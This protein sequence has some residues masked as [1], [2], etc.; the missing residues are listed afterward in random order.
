MKPPTFVRPL[1]TQEQEH[2]EAVLRARDAITLRRS[3]ILLASAQGY[4]PS[5]MAPILGCSVQSIRNAIHAFQAE[6]LNCLDAKPFAPKRVAMLWPRDR[7]EELRGLLHQS[8]RTFGKSRSTWTLK[9]IA[10]VWFEQGITPRRLSDEAIRWNLER[11]G[12]SCKRAR[13]WMTSPDPQYAAKKARRERL[14]NLAAKH[15]DWVLGFEDEVW[16]SRLAQPSMHAWT[17]GP[18][19]KVQVLKAADNDPDPDAV[20]CYGMLRNDTHKVM[21]RFVEGRPLGDVTIQF[22]SWACERLGA[23]GK[24]VLIVVWD[25]AS[26]HKADAVTGW[27]R[28]HNEHA[29]RGGG[30]KVVICELPVASPWLNNIEPCWTHA[31]RAVMEP[32]RKL[33]AQEIASRVCDH[34][35]CELLPYLKTQL[36]S[37]G[38]PLALLPLDP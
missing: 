20:C 31:K 9:L 26:W 16:W 10:E 36:A 12:I 21:L 13:S 33:T 4:K 37:A 29:R 11:M 6:A 3:Q 27:V 18:P 5:E 24:R 2:L 7:D 15:P 30:V 32:D 22:L 14:I 1:T 28:Q 25:E 8:P 17:D 23:E 19:M 38:E 34:F 35:G